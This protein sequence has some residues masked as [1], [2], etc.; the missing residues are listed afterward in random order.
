MMCSGDG[1]R[2]MSK[3]IQALLEAEKGK[4]TDSPP[5]P[6][7]RTQ[8]C[9]HLDFSPGSIYSLLTS[10]LNEETSPQSRKTRE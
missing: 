3:G 8:L 1:G 9:Q 10:S 6:I 7:E 2:A 4:E 5:Q